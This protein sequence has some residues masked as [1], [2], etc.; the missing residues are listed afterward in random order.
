MP[1]YQITHNSSYHFDE[2]VENLR[3]ECCLTPQNQPFQTIIYHKLYF[4]PLVKTQQTW[5]DSF[6]N[7]KQTL[8]FK[9]ALQRITVTSLITVAVSSQVKLRAISA[10]A[11]DAPL[12][13]SLFTQQELADVTPYAVAIGAEVFRDE[14]LGKKTIYALANYL[15]ETFIYDHTATEVDTPLQQ[16]FTQKRGVCQ[17]FAR[18]MIAVLQLNAIQARYVSGYLYTGENTS[19]LIRQPA[20][21]AWVSVFIP[22]S[23]WVDIDPTNNR[24][25]DENYIALAWGRDYVDVVPVKGMLNENRRQRIKVSVTIEKLSH[26]S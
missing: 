26:S 7:I 9:R 20:S 11:N 13:G 14:K 23:G 21:H 17:D 15:F 19:E 25:A 18:V 10:V 4:Q 22:S 16:L 1:N 2:P 6:D 5:I 8:L 3:L 24:W 12:W